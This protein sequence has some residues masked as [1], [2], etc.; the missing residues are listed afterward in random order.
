MLIHHI[1]S[2]HGLSNVLDLQVNFHRTPSRCFLFYLH[3][4]NINQFARK[5]YHLPPPPPPPPAPRTVFV[6]EKKYERDEGNY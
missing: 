2:E 5:Y 3:L 6:W 4:T 1:Y